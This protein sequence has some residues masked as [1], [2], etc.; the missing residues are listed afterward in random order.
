MVMDIQPQSV[1]NLLQEALKFIK[2]HWKAIVSLF[3]LLRFFI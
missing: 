3:C 2:S 1:S